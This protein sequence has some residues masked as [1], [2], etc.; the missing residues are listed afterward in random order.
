MASLWSLGGLLPWLALAAFV[1]LRVRRP[2]PLPH[3]PG[4]RDSAPALVTVIVPARNEAHNI[5][6]CLGTLTRSAYPN[7]EIVVVDDRSTDGT[8]SL[9]RRVPRGNARRLA[10]IHGEPLPEGCMG[11]PWAC[12][13]GYLRAEGELFLFTDADTRHAPLLLGRAVAALEEE[14]TDAVTVLG[15]QVLVSFW[16]QV[17][18]PQIILLLLLRYPDVSQPRGPGNWRSAIANGQFILIRR[19]A[20]ESVGG[21][22][23]VRAEVAE[24]LRLAQELCRAGRRLVVRGA[25]DALETRMYRSL[26]EIVEG[27]SKNIATGA[28]QCVEPWLA[29]FALPVL[30]TFLLGMWLLPPVALGAWAL[31]RLAGLVTAEGVVQWVSAAMGAS[32]LIWIAGC[33]RFRI[34]AGY[35][36]LYPLGAA[37]AAMIAVRSGMRGRRI[38]W[39]GRDYDGPSSSS[40][41][42]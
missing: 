20:Y 12:W 33:L 19:S 15:H 30:V 41:T 23:A 31:A 5:V 26:A 37:V 28:R 2:P 14:G 1:F 7:Y 38:R 10:V 25:E 8:P 32:L 11:K 42:C 21:H 22:A 17:V 40:A 27:W 18:M 36:V 9:A 35:A 29:P 16:E 6:E 4:M 39:K 34:P 3:P 13:Q 24:D